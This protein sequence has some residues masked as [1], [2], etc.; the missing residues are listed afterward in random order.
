MTTTQ[1]KSVVNSARHIAPT[2][3]LVRVSFDMPREKLVLLL[4]EAE[5]RSNLGITPLDDP[6]EIKAWEE[7]ASVLR[8]AI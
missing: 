4:A 6:F 7:F 2:R 1:A 3:D 5:L 8:R